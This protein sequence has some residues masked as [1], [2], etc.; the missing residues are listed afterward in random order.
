MSFNLVLITD[1]LKA[2]LSLTNA[3]ALVG[4]WILYRVTIMV[5]N[6]SPLHPLYRF[7]GS[8]VAAMSYI[9][10]AYFDWWLTGRYGIEI[11]KMHE[12]YGERPH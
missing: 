8:K 1:C 6:I 4:L 3:A 12:K 9:Y 11:R 2:V 5:Y 10:E 7:P